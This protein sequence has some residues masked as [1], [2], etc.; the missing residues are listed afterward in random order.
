MYI[1]IAMCIY[2]Y[3]YMYYY[4]RRCSSQSGQSRIF[5]VPFILRFSQNGYML[6]ES[7]G[8]NQDFHRRKVM[9]FAR[10]V[11]LMIIVIIVIAM[12]I[13]VDRDIHVYIYI[14]IYI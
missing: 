8:I 13:R 5:T 3:I 11:I 10:K 2:I 7:I 6:L 14:Y 9:C 12:V 4:M 1:I